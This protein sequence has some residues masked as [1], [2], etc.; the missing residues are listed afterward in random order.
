MVEEI[1]PHLYRTEIPLPKSPL[2]AV[3]SYLLEDKGRF[4]IIDTGMNRE[5]CMRPMLSA[6]E[7]LK[8]DLLL[9]RRRSTSA[10]WKPLL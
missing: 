7:E 2:K 3:N 8:V 10:R 6:L 5:E 9:R 1:L 4:L